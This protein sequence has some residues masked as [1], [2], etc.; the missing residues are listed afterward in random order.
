MKFVIES[1]ENE[2]KRT[3]MLVAYCEQVAALCLSRRLNF[4]TDNM[5]N[6]NCRYS[7]IVAGPRF[8][9]RNR[10]TNDSSAL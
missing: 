5:D 2:R 7:R 8:L 1:E 6:Q 3:Q 10:N 4:N 9:T